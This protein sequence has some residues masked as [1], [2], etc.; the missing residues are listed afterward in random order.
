MKYLYLIRTSLLELIEYR[1][2]IPA[3]SAGFLI[4]L[5]LTLFLWLAVTGVNGEIFSYSREEIVLYYLFLSGVLPL[6]IG[7]VDFSQRVG[8]DIKNGDLGGILLKPVTPFRYYTSLAV[9][10]RIK[11]FV[12]TVPLV[13]LAGVM[14]RTQLKLV[15]TN[16][17]LLLIS[18]TFTFVLSHLFMGIVGLMA[19]WTTEINWTSTFIGQVITLFSGVRFP[20]SFYSKQ[21]L[22]LVG[23]TPFLYF[24]FFPAEIFLKRNTGN[25]VFPFFVQVFWV[26]FLFLALNYLWKRGIKRYE[27]SSQ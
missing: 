2:N 23:V 3:R 12:T 5:F 25:F 11:D 6:V 13:V 8:W 14:F 4:N 15:P 19:F 9:S 17:L 22:G 16:V 27:G 20:V 26:S 18:L 10:E 24:G 1:V 7:G 21:I